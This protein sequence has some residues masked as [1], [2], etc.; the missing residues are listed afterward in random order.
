MFIFSRKTDKG[1]QGLVVYQI[2]IKSPKI[3][4]LSACAPL[5][6]WLFIPTLVDLSFQDIFQ[7]LVGGGQG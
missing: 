3:P 4:A 6:Y 2:R 1:R 7:S 5:A